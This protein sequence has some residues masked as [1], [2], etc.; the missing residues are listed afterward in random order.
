[1]TITYRFI[2]GSN[3]TPTELD[4]NFE[5]V[6]A[7]INAKAA[8]GVGVASA[9]LI[10]PNQLQF[11]LTDHSYLPPI[12]LPT[13]TFGF[14]GVWTPSTPYLVND[15]FSHGPSGYIVLVQHTSAAT[16]DPHATDG[17]G[18]DLYG[19]FFA[20][21]NVVPTGGVDGAVLTKHSSA[22]YDV[23]WNLPTLTGLSDVTTTPPAAGDLVQ[24]DGHEF[25]YV[26]TSSIASSPPSLL[27]LTDVQ[28]PPNAAPHDQQ[29]VYWEDADQ[30]F[31]FKD[32]KL[33]TL[34][35]VQV[36]LGGGP[37]YGQTL[38]YDDT[39]GNLKW[40]NGP[41]L[42]DWRQMTVVNY[43]LSV[44]DTGRF[45]DYTNNTPTGVIIPTV[46]HIVSTSGGQGW[47]DSA[48]I[49]I[50]QQ[51]AGQVTFTP[52]SGVTLSFLPAGKLPATRTTGSVIW[53]HCR[54]GNFWTVWGDLA[55]DPAWAVITDA[56]TIDLTTNAN[57]TWTYTPTSS[58]TLGLASAPF[59]R[60]FTI[61]VT[62]SG[63]TPYTVT[64]G[65]GFTTSG[66]LVTGAVS[67]AVFTI[68][69][70][71]DGTNMNEVER[72]TG[73]GYLSLTGGTLSGPLIANAPIDNKSQVVS[74][75]GATLAINRALGEYCT[76][77][78]SSS[79]TT[80]TATG[81]P[82]SGTRGRIRIEIVNGGAFT[83]TGW[84]TGT[85]WPGGTAPTIT[86]GSG[87]RDIVELTTNNG[88]TT[89]YG[90]VLGQDFH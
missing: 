53:A 65:G 33:R 56:M 87:K 57:E 76:L 55:D 11:Q 69:F 52:A 9:T 4:G 16:F 67:G 42:F 85:I 35:D 20:A 5:T 44:Y 46:A 45:F 86:S 80:M 7:M 12:L 26:P 60:R 89:I 21:P 31:E 70:L 79:I 19:V 30:L 75:S 73:V 17:G 10:P 59:G 28:V 14:R 13:A 27:T 71:G 83:I 90:R 63:T 3:L 64:F 34:P 88:G 62:T 24:F 51:A 37:Y 22:D 74:Q 23:I 84:P 15:I 32:V 66:P 6:E 82:T 61:I 54:G 2:K 39:T 48:L 38:Y 78:M 72:F 40:Y 47:A 77:A 25:A 43:T 81:W 49:G 1:M 36:T 58:N 29:V 50:R 68:S 18:H 41:S 8:Q